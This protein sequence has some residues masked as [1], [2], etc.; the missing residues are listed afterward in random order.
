MPMHPD[1]RAKIVNL[2]AKANSYTAPTTLWLGLHVSSLSTAALPST[3]TEV[4]RTGTG[5]A[6]MPVT[7]AMLTSATTANSSVVLTTGVQFPDPLTNWSTV[8]ALAV[9]DSSVTSGGSAST[10]IAF[11][12]LQSTVNVTAGNPVRLSSGTTLGFSFGLS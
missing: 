5:Y 1:W 11:A 10:C 6:R 8:H 4:A 3:A 9:Y 12:N 7:T 2:I